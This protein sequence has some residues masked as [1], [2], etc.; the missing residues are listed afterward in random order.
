MESNFDSK[1]LG[2]KNTVR[3]EGSPLHLKTE[4]ILL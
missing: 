1:I 3:M 4:A 2:N